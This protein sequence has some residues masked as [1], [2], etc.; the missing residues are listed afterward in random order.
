MRYSR[1]QLKSGAVRYRSRPTDPV[2]GHRM[3]IEADSLEEL[4]TRLTRV[5]GVRD[6]LRWG[7]ITRKQAAERLRPAAAHGTMTVEALWRRYLVTVPAGSRK[8][9]EGHWKYR[10]EQ[11]GKL[12]VEELTREVMTNWERELETRGFAPKT[13]KGAYDCLASCL[14]LAVDGSLIDGLPWGDVPRS[15]GGTGYRPAHA[16]PR[17][18]GAVGTVDQVAALV[19]AARALDLRLAAKCRYTG[20]SARVTFL[21]L[22]GLRQAEG[23]AVGWSDLEIDRAPYTLRVHR[24]ARAQWHKEPGA[25]SEPNQPT[26]TRTSRTQVLHD[27]VVLALRAHRAELQRRG[28]YSPAGPVFP[29]DSGEWRTSGRLIKPERVRELVTAAGLPSAESWVT[30]SLRHSFATLEVVASGGDLRRTQ[31]RTGHASLG[32]LETYLHTAG[33]A[34]GRSAVPE[35]PLASPAIACHLPGLPPG[36][37]ITRPLDLDPWGIERADA[38]PSLLH[39]DLARARQIEDSR[40]LEKR[41]LRDQSERSFRELAAEWL[42]LPGNAGNRGKPQAISEAEKRAYCR[43]YMSAKRAGLPVESCKKAGQ[44]ARIATEGA[45]RKQLTAAQNRLKTHTDSPGQPGPLLQ[46]NHQGT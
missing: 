27:N 45:W 26:K 14:R 2:T 35:L 25:G 43:A 42:T 11:L 31:A 34:L 15:Q 28:W 19:M 39:A 1:I 24:Q 12:A 40:A 29:G 18:R 6:D 4:R 5:R 38:P 41:S 44:R 10:L 33:G 17:E 37:E 20:L 36:T 13:R 32:Q 22:T 23:C 3:S 21:I 30:H 16:Q 8:I 7:G 46:A 9:V